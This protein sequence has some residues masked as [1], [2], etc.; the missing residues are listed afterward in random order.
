MDWHAFVIMKNTIQE[1]IYTFNYRHEIWMH[2]MQLDQKL[3][4]TL[5]FIISPN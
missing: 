4:D 2:Y 1:N 3:L 5:I